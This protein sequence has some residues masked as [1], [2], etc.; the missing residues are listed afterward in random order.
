MCLFDEKHEIL[1]KNPRCVLFIL[2][3]MLSKKSISR[4]KYSFRLYIFGLLKVLFCINWHSDKKTIVWI[5]IRWDG[6]QYLSFLIKNRNHN[7][8][9]HTKSLMTK[10][11]ISYHGLL[12]IF[13]SS[14]GFVGNKISGVEN[15]DKTIIGWTRAWYRQLRFRLVLPTKVEEDKFNNICSCQ[16]LR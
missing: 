9:Y 13:P 3:I 5:F 7:R 10:T 14:A 16:M 8:S 11:K 12:R 2:K 15:I 4:L 1:P 6:I